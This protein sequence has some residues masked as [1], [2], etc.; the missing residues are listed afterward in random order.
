MEKQIF[1]QQKM[2]DNEYHVLVTLAIEPLYGYRIC[3]EVEQMT[4][5]GKR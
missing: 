1:A 2:N 5:D 4:R 3:K